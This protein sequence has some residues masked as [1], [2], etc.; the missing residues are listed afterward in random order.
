MS[1]CIPTYVMAS[2]LIAG[3]MNWWQA[4]GTI[5]LG[6]LIVLVPMLNA[7]PTHPPRMHSGHRYRYLRISP[8]LR[9]LASS[10]SE[11]RFRPASD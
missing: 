3:G 9:G 5:L 1:V 4:V 2:G 6:N 10:I 7:I 11:N 8:R